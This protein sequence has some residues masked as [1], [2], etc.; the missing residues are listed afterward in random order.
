MRLAKSAA[1]AVDV[2]AF[3]FENVPER[4]ALKRALF[5]RL[6]PLLADETILVSNTSSLPGSLMAD[7]SARPDRFV[8]ANFSHLGHQKVEVMPNR[9]SNDTVLR[10]PTSCGPGSILL[11]RSNSLR[12]QPRL[13]C[14]QEGGAAPGRRRSHCAAGPRSRLDARLGGADGAVR[15]DGPDRTGRHSR[16]RARLRRPYA[17]PVRST[18]PVP[19]ADGAGRE[20]GGEV[21]R[22]VLSLSDP[23]FARPDFLQHA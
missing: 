19:R 20:V 12:L 4:L 6:A 23:D 16:H 17:R 10:R 3:V 7:A 15:A 1:E 11:P 9:S 22:R 2:A 13:A 5:A 14:R 21:G 8:N 18:A